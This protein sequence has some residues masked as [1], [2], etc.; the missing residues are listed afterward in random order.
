VSSSSTP[1]AE[2]YEAFRNYPLKD[3]IA[4][5]PHC[6]LQARGEAFHVA[7]L[8]EL[9]WQDLGVFLFKSM[10][11]FGDRDDFKHFLP[12]IV[13]SFIVDFESNPYGPLAVTIE[14]S[15]CRMAN[16]A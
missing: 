15:L 9:S 10:T 12:R 3:Y 5:C 2:I 11:T 16:L 7:P 8:D 1:I 6:D 4:G 13:E 14:T